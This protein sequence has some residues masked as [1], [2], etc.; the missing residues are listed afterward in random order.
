[1]KKQLLYLALATTMVALSCDKDDDTPSLTGY[2]QGA[3]S[4]SP[5]GPLNSNWS[6]L[7]RENGTVR[8]FDDADTNIAFKAEGVYNI[9]GRTV[10][11]QYTYSGGGGTYSSSG[12]LN[13]NSSEIT[14][15][16]G[17]GSSSSSAGNF[18]LTRQ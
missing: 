14:G 6:M 15:T 9:T 17:T 12:E 5:G 4:T 11:T 10:R 3:Y 1:M 13:A 18:S 8:V 7:F 2:W 16:W